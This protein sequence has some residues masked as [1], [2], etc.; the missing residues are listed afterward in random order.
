MVSSFVQIVRSDVDLWYSVLS[1]VFSASLISFVFSFVSTKITMIVTVLLLSTLSAVLFFGW[2]NRWNTM[3]ASLLGGTFTA[4]LL[5]SLTAHN[6]F[7]CIFC[8]YLTIVSAFHYSEYIVTAVA[9]RHDLRHSSYL[10][11]HSSSYWAAALTSWLEFL[12]EV[13]F[14]PILKV[15]WLSYCGILIT[16][17]G[18]IIRKAAMFHSGGSF[19]HLVAHNKRPEHKLITDGV[20]GYVR[21]PAYVGW[22]IWSLGTQV[23]LCNPL[24]LIL[25]LIVGWNFF[26]ERI[27]VEERYLT[28]FFGREYTEYQEKVPVGIPFIE[29]YNVRSQLRVRSELSEK[30]RRSFRVINSN[31]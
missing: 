27:Y 21:H 11:N 24:C 8:R 26:N 13:R 29:G 31:L 22:M 6:L 25:Y 23:I 2:H 20:Y 30:K 16:L 19:T 4:S 17:L 12:F 10:L 28:C 1:A 14:L 3:Q 18:E 9:N 5:Y 15:S 7:F